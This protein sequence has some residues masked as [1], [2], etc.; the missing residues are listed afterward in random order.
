MS[1]VTTESLKRIEAQLQEARA[2]RRQ[3][4]D[5]THA[6]D[7]KVAKNTISLEDHMRRTDANEVRIKHAEKF[8]WYFLGLV[9][10]ITILAEILGRSI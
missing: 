7:I 10:I 4:L 2:D 9:T 6:I 3:I 1:D 8:K 5:K